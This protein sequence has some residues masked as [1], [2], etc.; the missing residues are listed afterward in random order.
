MAV[1]ARRKL[2]GEFFVKGGTK[3]T[4]SIKSFLYPQ[5]FQSL[6]LIYQLTIKLIEDLHPAFLIRLL[7]GLYFLLCLSAKPLVPPTGIEPARLF[8]KGF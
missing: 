8:T 5:Y 1:E 2:I 3:Y 7:G 6:Q 4:A